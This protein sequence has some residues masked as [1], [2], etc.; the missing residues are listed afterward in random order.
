MSA[1]ILPKGCLPPL[2]PVCFAAGRGWREERVGSVLTNNCR[3]SWRT[4]RR[5][6]PVEHPC[7]LFLPFLISV[8]RQKDPA[9]PKAVPRSW[10]TDNLHPAG[11]ARESHKSDLLEHTYTDLRTCQRSQLL[12]IP[13]PS[14]KATLKTQPV[15]QVPFGLTSMHTP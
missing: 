9:Y 13:L 6:L 1:F 8:P 14:R 7:L 5:Q 10:G 2:D 11:T 12:N 4:L 15:T 3:Q